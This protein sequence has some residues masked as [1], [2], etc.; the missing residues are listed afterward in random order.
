MHKLAIAAALAIGLALASAASSAAAA[1][2]LYPNRFTQQDRCGT[3]W[4]EFVLVDYG[5]STG[6]QSNDLVKNPD[7]T[8]TSIHTALD[9]YT[10]SDGSTVVTR[11]YPAFTNVPCGPGERGK[12]RGYVG[13]YPAY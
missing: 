11:N 1:T 6:H 5:P 10:F 8:W 7:G 9:G 2:T 12:P 13:D 3:K 4:D